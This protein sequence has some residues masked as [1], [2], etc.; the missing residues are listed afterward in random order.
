MGGLAPTA[1]GTPTPIVP[2]GPGIKPLA[3]NMVGID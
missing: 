3:E 1:N 2:Y